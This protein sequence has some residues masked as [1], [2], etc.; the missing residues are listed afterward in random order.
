MED[1]AF[2]SRKKESYKISKDIWRSTKGKG[3]MAQFELETDTKVVKKMELS[4]TPPGAGDIPYLVISTGI[5]LANGVDNN[6]FEGS[7]IVSFKKPGAKLYSDPQIVC[8]PDQDIEDMELKENGVWSSYQFYKYDEYKYELESFL[9]DFLEDGFVTIEVN[10]ETSLKGE[11]IDERNDRK[12]NL[13]Y[14]INKLPREKET[15]DFLVICEDQMFPCHKAILSARSSVF[16]NMFTANM[17]EAA[18]GRWEVK[19]STPEAVEIMTDFIYSG[20]IDYASLE[21]RPEEIL[22]LANFYDLPD[23]TYTAKVMI[24]WKLSP[25]NALSTLV[26]FERYAATDE[27][28]KKEVIGF[29]KKNVKGVVDSA[30]WNKFLKNHSSL[31]K[32]VMKGIAL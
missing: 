31:V 32:D 6:D 3:G 8:D 1:T 16:S 18:T 24:V 26:N 5:K 14:D 7:V 12:V 13:A 4:I 21:E 27:V 25:E 9:K 15:C 19:D 30:D 2:I 20:K 23:L 17:L 10:T 28:V 22:H 29:I 11:L